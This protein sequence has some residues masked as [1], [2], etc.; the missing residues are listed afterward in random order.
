MGGLL[1]PP[2]TDSS[3]AA[4]AAPAVLDRGRTMTRINSSHQSLSAL[5]SLNRTQSALMQWLTRLSTGQRINRGRDDPAGLVAA[6]SLARQIV[7]SSAAITSNERSD[8]TLDTADSALAQMSSALNDIS[9]RAV[10]SANTGAMAPGEMQANQMMIDA[11]VD[12]VNRTSATA[13]FGGRPLLDG[14]LTVQVMPDGQSVTVP[15]VRA[16]TLGQPGGNEPGMPGDRT[17]ESVR[18]GGANSLANGG[19]AAV[20]AIAGRAATQVAMLRGRIGAF[21]KYGLE[22]TNSTLA[23]TRLNLITAESNIRDT[24]MAEA[25]AHTVAKQIAMTSGLMVLAM[26]NRSRSGVLSL[27]A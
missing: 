18:T 19:A 12:A 13:G 16:S 26:T 15:K 14:S 21:Q 25:T 22:A 3:S 17:L 20:A 2:L 1:L 10:A 27:L 4:G 11:A 7:E 8:R 23:D 24:D 5:D 6:E 9:A